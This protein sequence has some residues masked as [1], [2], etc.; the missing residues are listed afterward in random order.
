MTNYELM[1]EAII[2]AKKSIS[3]DSRTHPKVGAII[4]DVS[5]DIILRAH[6]GENNNGGHAEYMLLKKAKENNI[7]LSEATLYVTLEPCTSRGP[8][9]IPCAQRIADSGIRNVF[10]G[11]LDPNPIICGRGETYLRSKMNVER[12]PSYLIKKIE[13]DNK[14][15]VSKYSNKLLP[16]SS[17]YVKKQISDLII[18]YLLKNDILVKAIPFDWD[19]NIDDLIQFINVRQTDLDLEEYIRKARMYAYDC[20]YANYD[21]EFDSRNIDINKWKYEFFDILKQLN[22]DDASNYKMI[23]IGAGNG[24]EVKELFNDN[25][26]LTLVDIGVESLK[27]AKALCTNSKIIHNEAENL[28]DVQTCSQD[29]YISLRVYQSSYFNIEKAL[30]EAYRVL[31]SCG[32]LII[33]IANGFINHEKVL[34]PGL[35]FPNSK[36]V[37]RNRPYELSEKIRRKMT[38]LKFE[39]VGIRSTNSEIYIFGRKGN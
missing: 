36:I 30:L 17:L 22:V 38:Q 25:S 32:V 2:E 31:V 39:D 18:E 37:D 21:Y 35:V 23:D 1:N 11:M 26:Y 33:S 3:E 34:I 20:K 7:D 13:E 10:I 29:I 8:G 6:R 19:F 5:G 12:F 28:K 16:D 4:I 15:F 14:E 24:V 9:K 27:K